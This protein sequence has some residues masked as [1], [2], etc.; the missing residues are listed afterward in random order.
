MADGGKVVLA[1]H[2]YRAKI[3]NAQYAG[4]VRYCRPR[5]WKV[6]DACLGRAADRAAVRRA[7][8]DANIVGVISSLGVPLPADALAGRPAVFF[9]CPKDVAFAGSPHICHDAD[10]TAHLAVN[11]LMTLP[12]RCFAYAHSPCDLYWS[13][14]RGR[15]FEGE[16]IR[17]GGALQPAFSRP[18]VFDKRRLVPEL[19]KWIAALPKPCGIFA[20]NDEMARAVIAA[21]RQTA[22]KIPGDV[23]VVGVDDDPKFC[24][25]KPSL[26]S[27]VPD[28]NAGA[29]LA[30]QTLDRLVRG[31]PVAPDG[32]TFRP[33]GLVSRQ[34]TGHCLQSNGEPNVL[35]AVKLIREKACF[36]LHASEVLAGMRGSRRY[37]EQVFRRLTGMSVLEMIRK[38]RFENAKVLL[39]TTEKPIAL[40]GEL[41]GS[42]SVTTFCREF[43][44]ET[45][46]SPAAWRR[47]SRI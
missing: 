26:T 22:A 45:G 9:D 42:L 29:F 13:R 8:R 10:Q 16:I 11:E 14:D 41:S 18:G 20:A 31:V 37:A 44:A 32:M 40:V 47:K 38:V 6:K 23:A 4:L 35:A 15:A 21:C 7:L 17:R 46:L 27:V 12:L 3:W 36:G 28:W 43:K 24:L 2:A 39:E 34:S 5:G 33:M 30:A 19:E 25:A 1:L